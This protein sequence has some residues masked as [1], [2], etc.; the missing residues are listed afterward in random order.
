MQ[1]S[2]SHDSTL[3]RQKRVLK[4]NATKRYINERDCILVYV[5]FYHSQKG[6]R[7]NKRNQ[8]VLKTQWVHEQIEIRSLGCW[9][10]KYMRYPKKSIFSAIHLVVVLELNNLIAAWSVLHE[11]LEAHCVVNSKK[12][13]STIFFK[14]LQ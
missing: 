14:Q 4:K 10:L 6:D 5:V 11:F 3:I 2:H 1:L 13:S 7:Q 9:C 8:V 12:K